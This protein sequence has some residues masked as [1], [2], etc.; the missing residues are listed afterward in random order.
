[1]TNDA[2]RAIITRRHGLP[3]WSDSKFER[4]REVLKGFKRPGGPAGVPSEYLATGIGRLL[5][6]ALR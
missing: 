6:T 2:V 4:L 1:M 5:V 3:A